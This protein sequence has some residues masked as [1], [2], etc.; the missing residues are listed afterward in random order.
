MKNRQIL[1]LWSPS[2]LRQK[3]LC[4]SKQ[5]NYLF[6]SNCDLY[7][8]YSDEY[9]VECYSPACMRE[10]ELKELTTLEHKLSKEQIFDYAIEWKKVVK[11]NS[12]MRIMEND[13]VKS[14][15][16]DYYNNVILDRLKELREVK[17]VSLTANLMRDY[18]LS[19]IFIS[20]LINRLIES[21]KIKIVRLCSTL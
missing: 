15:S 5:N 11:D 18:Y 13:K 9:D 1:S 4:F 2:P 19:D 10:K 20:Y 6:N 12:D 3:I 8:V 21:N 14:V 16:F 17:S 7:V